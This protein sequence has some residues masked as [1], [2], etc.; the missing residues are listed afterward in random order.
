MGITYFNST[1]KLLITINI[2]IGEK[3]KYTYYLKLILLAFCFCLIQKPL[4][5]QVFKFEYIINNFKPPNPKLHE[6]N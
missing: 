4:I 3:L 1:A 2:V 5:L 6:D